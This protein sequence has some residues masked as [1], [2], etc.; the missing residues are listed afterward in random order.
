LIE[1]ALAWRLLGALCGEGYMSTSSHGS[2][3]AGRY[4]VEADL[5]GVAVA[6]LHDLWWHSLEAHET[7]PVETFT[8]DC[9]VV[10]H[11]ATTTACADQSNA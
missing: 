4:H 7:P 9:P 6:V 1:F 10:A 3:I 8:P 11:E 2:P 5:N